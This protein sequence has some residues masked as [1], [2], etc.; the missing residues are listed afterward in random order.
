MATTRT[1]AVSND[2]YS[3]LKPSVL[4][5][6]RK[7]LAD[8]INGVSGPVRCAFVGDSTMSGFGIGSGGSGSANDARAR[9]W[10]RTLARLLTSGGLP[11][12]ENSMIGEQGM[13]VYVPY[14]SYDTRCVIG[15]GWTTTGSTVVPGG[16]AFLFDNHNA[17]GF[18]NASSTLS[19]T[20]TD[21]IDSFTVFYTQR[22][23]TLNCN[24]DGGAAL[25]VASGLGAG[26]TLVTLPGSYAS[27]SNGFSTYTT[28]KAAHTINVVVQ[29]GTTTEIIGIRAWDS[30]ASYLDIMPLAKTGATIAIADSQTGFYS[31]HWTGYNVGAN[32]GF[33]IL[34]MN[35]TVN[36]INGSTTYASYTASLNSLIPTYVAANGNT[37]VVFIIGPWGILNGNTPPPQIPVCQAIYDYAAAHNW[38]VIDMSYRWANGGQANLTGG[39]NVHPTWSGGTDMARE[40]A[41]QLL[42]L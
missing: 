42:A 14:G 21:A 30:T 11:A 20:P 17:G 37:I 34:F 5:P 39:D 1:V 18:N 29:S 7:K 8:V 19:F 24:V 28:T 25:T 41:R 38:P 31:T 6:L 22:G 36:D 15:G 3:V 32:S 33:D 35:M 10:P 40:V 4:A 23:G 13:T 12:K 9:M 27:F 2:A 16:F 26:G